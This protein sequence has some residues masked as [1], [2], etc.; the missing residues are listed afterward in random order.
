[1]T[2]LF[3]AGKDQVISLKEKAYFRNLSLILKIKKE[4]FFTIKAQVKES[5]EGFSD[6]QKFS[7][8]AF[9]QQIHGRL[10]LDFKESESK[11]IILYLHQS[12]KCESEYS[13]K[14]LILDFNISQ[15]IPSKKQFQNEELQDLLHEISEKDWEDELTSFQEQII[16]RKVSDDVSRFIKNEEQKA[17][18]PGAITT[19]CITLLIYLLVSGFSLISLTVGIFFGLF[20]CIAGAGIGVIIKRYLLNKD[21]LLISSPI[22]NKY[23]SYAMNAGELLSFWDSKVELYLHYKKEF[24]ADKIKQASQTTGECRKVLYELYELKED[25]LEIEEKLKEQIRQMSIVSEEASQMSQIIQRVEDQMMKKVYELKAMIQQEKLLEK[26]QYDREALSSK[27][28]QVLG[29][30]EKINAEWSKE[31]T[32]LK[33]QISG[34][35]STFQ[36]QI[37]HTKDLVMA[38]IELK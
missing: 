18:K 32:E 30:G 7:P 29:K 13:K 27:I 3:E 12:I 38:E 20:T 34:M 6:P 24:L 19:F 31:K 2:F 8:K 35:M 37:L 17:L 26:Q 15:N 33:S 11:S 1:M 16:D 28:N 22:R 4:D 10:Q 36:K 9:L 21:Y 23:E 25:N 14:D 5:L